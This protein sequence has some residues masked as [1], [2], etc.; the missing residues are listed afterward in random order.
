MSSKGSKLTTPHKSSAV[1][2]SSSSTPSRN[3]RSSTSTTAN[4]TIPAP[5]PIFLTLS[6]SSFAALTLTHH[7]FFHVYVGRIN[8]R[9]MALPVVLDC[10]S[11]LLVDTGIGSG[12]SR[13]C[14][15]GSVVLGRLFAHLPSLIADVNVAKLKNVKDKPN[16]L[17][18][19]KVRDRTHTRAATVIVVCVRG[20]SLDRVCVCLLCQILFTY[21]FR[22]THSK[23]HVMVRAVSTP[24]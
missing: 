10:H 3:Q 13:A 5:P 6:P 9:L 18:T 11:S 23:Y 14:V 2:H 24:R 19:D 7:N 21:Q 15:S 1:S 8:G 16:L 20:C 17:E 4:T 22:E 12:S